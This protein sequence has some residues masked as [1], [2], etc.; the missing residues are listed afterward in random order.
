MCG[1][2]NPLQKVEKV[3]DFHPLDNVTNAPV[4]LID[5]SLEGFASLDPAIAGIASGGKTDLGSPRT[6]HTIGRAGV[7]DMADTAAFFGHTI[8]TGLLAGS[9][10]GGAAE[11]AE[12]AGGAGTAVG[13]GPGG[14]EP[15][16]AQAQAASAAGAAPETLGATSP[17]MPPA[18]PEPL[19]GPTAPGGSAAPSATMPAAVPEP[20][21]GPAAPGGSAYEPPTSPVQQSQTNPPADEKKAPSTTKTVLDSLSTASK[22]L[23]PASSLLAAAAGVKAIKQSKTQAA[24]ASSPSSPTSAPPSPPPVAPLPVFNSGK[25]VLSAPIVQRS[26]IQDQIARRGR[27]STILTNDAND[28]LGG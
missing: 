3:L 7:Q 27:A 28:R 24:Q 21:G 2:G 6:A 15:G 5:P 4:P 26:V 20:S 23:G 12:A 22:I 14:V 1:G 18:S 17:S 10:L 25:G 9:A 13:G 8:A 19:G 16:I 11:P